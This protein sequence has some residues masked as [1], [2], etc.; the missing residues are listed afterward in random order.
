MG[1]EDNE[2][3]NY[4]DDFEKQET[5]RNSRRG[6]GNFERNFEVIRWSGLEPNKMKIIRALGGIPNSA[7]AD[8]FTS[9]I[10]QVG[11]L[12]SDAGKSFRC[13][14]PLREDQ[15]EHIMWRIIG[16]V[17]EV[18]YINRK[19]VYVNEEK[20]KD[21]FDI[22]NFN[23]LLET[24]PKRK[25]DKGWT[26]RQVIV[27]NVIDREQMDWH[28]ENKHSM[29]LSRNVSMSADGTR[30][31][32]DEG[33]PIYGFY[34]AIVK[35]LFKN[36]GN[37]EGYDIGIVRLGTTQQPY[38]IVNASAFVAGKIPEVPKDLAPLVSLDAGLT[39][40]EAGWERYDLKKLYSTS[41]F[42]KLYNNLKVAFARIDATL[43]TKFTAELEF[44]MEKE[45]K[46]RADRAAENADAA[47]ATTGAANYP[48]TA[49]TTATQ[50]A[51]EAIPTAAPTRARVTTPSVSA[52]TLTADKLAA[53]HGWA[54]IPPE[55]QSMIVDVILDKK[56][57][58]AVDIK[59][60]PDP[61]V[62]ACPKCR[63][64]APETFAH[65]PA[66]G[67]SFTG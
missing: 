56:T 54:S 61:G 3:L 39:E 41:S 67:I 18:A 59:Y 50:S 48:A 11:W 65:C 49:N 62:V 42:T 64:P 40:E 57:G 13:V 45:K 4:A 21:I 1:V 43:G 35:G 44:E 30:E 22:V 29:L 27:M 53:L 36:Y 20:H 28:K 47:P 32:A 31:Y 24:D 25:Y 63:A 5:E 16:R 58:E 2:F 15:P 8:N 51:P 34:D 38:R 26:G 46:E 12:K 66:C 55:Q 52:V 9:R 7:S 6:G 10:V 19:R 17:N 14:L 60:D 37:W 23:G 33:V